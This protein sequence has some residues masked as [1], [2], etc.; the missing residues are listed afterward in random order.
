[1]I[2]EAWSRARCTLFQK[3]RLTRAK[4]TFFNR[5]NISP[6]QCFNWIV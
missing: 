3:N 1:M 2:T 4:F 6:N 5:Y